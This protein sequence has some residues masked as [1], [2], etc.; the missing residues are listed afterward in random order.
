MLIYLASP[1]SHIDPIE[2]EI[3]YN[4]VL[5]FTKRLILRHRLII[6]SPIVHNHHIAKDHEEREEKFAFDFWEKYDTKMISRC[7]ELWVYKI[8][9]YYESKGIKAEI[10]IA[11]SLSI[12]VRF[13]EENQERFTF[14]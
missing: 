2:R 9:G 12:R 6:Y 11:Q 3:R 5:E 10:A 7:D 8:D 1:Y 4:K 13:I 14:L